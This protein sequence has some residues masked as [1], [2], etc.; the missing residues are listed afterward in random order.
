MY[1]I[2]GP[3]QTQIGSGWRDSS[4]AKVNKSTMV[5]ISIR[6][7]ESAVSSLNVS[8]SNNKHLHDAGHCTCRA[9]AT[10]IRSYNNVG[11]DRT[12][13]VAASN[14]RDHCRAVPVR[15]ILEAAFR[16]TY[17]DRR[18]IILGRRKR[19]SRSLGRC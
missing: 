13:D 3:F 12:V 19:G 15:E 16:N 9:I 8:L 17:V 2:Y 5:T 1:L 18:T 10:Q 11:N 7:T 14:Q 4:N 6:L